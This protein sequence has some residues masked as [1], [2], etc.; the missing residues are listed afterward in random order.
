MVRSPSLSASVRVVAVVK[1]QGQQSQ[2]V[3]SHTLYIKPVLRSRIPVF[4]GILDTDPLVR[5]TDTDPDPSIIKQKL[6]ETLFPTVLR[7][8]FDF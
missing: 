6:G 4:L 1:P 3:L 5:G 8:L 2:H 7:F